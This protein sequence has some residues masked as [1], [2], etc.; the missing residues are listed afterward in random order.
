VT[1]V[2][3]ASAVMLVVFAAVFGT[4]SFGRRSGSVIENRLYCLHMARQTLEMLSYGTYANLKVG[5][6]YL[7][8]DKTRYYTVTE[9]S[10]GMTKNVN[11]VIGWKEPLGMTQSVSLAT[12]FSKS[13]HQ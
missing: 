4:V 5:T 13:L 1:E 9:D 12:S 2:V 3:V 10:D 11:I 6:T 7:S 8:T